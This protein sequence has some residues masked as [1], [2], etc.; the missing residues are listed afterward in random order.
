MHRDQLE[1]TDIRL[2]EA[3]AVWLTEVARV[4]GFE[5]VDECAASLKGQGEPGTLLR[6][7]YDERQRIFTEWRTARCMG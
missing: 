6:R 3:D 2:A 5:R 7:G 4:F 1:E